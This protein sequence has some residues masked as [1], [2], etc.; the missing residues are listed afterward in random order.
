MTQSFLETG[1]HVTIG[2]TLDK[3]HPR[4]WKANLLKCGSKQIGNCHNP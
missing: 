3:K 2:A 4:G 1:Q